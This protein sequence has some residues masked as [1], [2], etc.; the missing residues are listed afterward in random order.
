MAMALRGLAPDQ[1]RTRLLRLCDIEAPVG[2][3]RGSPGVP[4]LSIGE[5]YQGQKGLYGRY[6]DRDLNKKNAPKIKRAAPL[7]SPLRRKGSEPNR[8]GDGD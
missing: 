8:R 6:G 3:C 7:C 4:L 1:T 2:F 5:H